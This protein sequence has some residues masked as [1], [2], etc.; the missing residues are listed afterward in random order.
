MA[1]GRVSSAFAEAGYDS[2]GAVLDAEPAAEPG[3]IPGDDGVRSVGY[4]EV[5]S[6]IE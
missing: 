3:P 6:Y 1:S 2:L 4:E 5:S